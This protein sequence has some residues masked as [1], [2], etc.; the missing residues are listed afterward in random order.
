MDWSQANCS[1]FADLKGRGHQDNSSALRHYHYRILTKRYGTIRLIEAPQSRLKKLQRQILAQ[2]LEKIPPPHPSVHGFVKG[3]SVKTL[4]APHTGRHIILRIDLQDFFPSFAASRIQALFR[5]MGYPEAVADLLG[6]ICTNS[7]PRDV[8]SKSR[9]DVNPDLFRE[10]SDLYSK[11]HLPQGTPTSPALANLC[12]YRTDCRLA[13]LSRSV[14]AEYTRYADDLAFS[15]SAA[16]AGQVE[17]F[18]T[19]VAAILMEEGFTVHYRKTRV[20]RQGVRQH[21]AGLVVNQRMNVMRPDFDRL[22]AI[23]T[24][25]VRLGP[26]GQN[27][28]AHPRFRAHLEGRLGFVEMTN[29]AKG[30]RLR[31]IFEPI[32]WQ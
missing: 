28:E 23:L 30:K 27:R 4:V 32:R 15:G 16:F 29:P 21:L 19:H 13:G 26:E 25:C 2:I 5:T 14:G 10:A 8:W 6:G 17:R 9:F 20:M 31:K 7:V 11:P 1:G 22:K 3:R 18:S 12:T 24:N